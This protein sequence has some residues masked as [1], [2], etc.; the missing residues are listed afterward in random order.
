MLELTLH[1]PPINICPRSSYEGDGQPLEDGRWA[2]FRSEHVRG[3]ITVFVVNEALLR[4]GIA[5]RVAHPDL[6]FGLAVPD[7][8]GAARVVYMD[9]GKRRLFDESFY[10]AVHAIENFCMVFAKEGIIGHLGEDG[11][12]YELGIHVPTDA[13]K[14]LVVR[15]PRI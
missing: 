13:V 7:P 4:S 10:R 15:S 11:A 14:A 3:M 8:S 9:N 1:T 6:T 12:A 5:R 2:T